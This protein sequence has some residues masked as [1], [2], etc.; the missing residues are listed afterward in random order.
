M[1]PEELKIV[2]ELDCNP[3]FD[4]RPELYA[5]E[6][7]E[8]VKLVPDLHVTTKLV[9]KVKL[10]KETDT[11]RYNEDDIVVDEIIP[12]KR[13]RLV[14][15]IDISRKLVS[16]IMSLSLSENNRDRDQDLYYMRNHLMKF[17]E[18][19]RDSI[20]YELQSS[21]NFYSVDSSLYLLKRLFNVDCSD[22]K[23]VSKNK[24][25]ILQSFIAHILDT[26]EV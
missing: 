20:L 25:V 9:K 13:P 26:L 14:F 7:Q 18:K 22:V 8:D 17:S 11:L 2:G 4:E 10:R 24:E 15:G 5:L 1:N 12:E 23:C 16:I 6:I 3:I 19:G 21:L